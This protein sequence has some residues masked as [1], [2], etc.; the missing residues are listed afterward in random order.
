MPNIDKQR[1]YPTI[2]KSQ[3]FAKPVLRHLRKLIHDACP[4]VAGA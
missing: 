2:E 4:D 1:R 3:D